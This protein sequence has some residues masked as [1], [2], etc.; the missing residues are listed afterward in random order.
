[1]ETIISV[2]RDGSG[3]IEQTV[4]M[5]SDILQMMKSMSE[6]T[7]ASEFELLDKDEL[8]ENAGNM[9]S[10]VRFVSAEP[11]TTEGFEGYKAVYSFDDINTL[12]INQNPGEIV[13]AP[14]DEGA[15]DD[16]IKEI[17]TF[18]FTEGEPSMV[19][20]KFPLNEGEAL[21]QE[22]DE[23]QGPTPDEGQ[24]ELMKQ[25]YQNMHL[26]MKMRFEGTIQ[27]TNASYRNGS[28]LTLFEMDF[29]KIFSNE[30]AID[31]LINSKP[32]TIQ[33]MKSMVEETAGITAEMNET[34]TVRYY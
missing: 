30:K 12:R 2:K 31:T 8:R 28:E 26:S 23:Q 33:A 6:E 5:Q 15:E 13:P 34:V 29:G 16:Q 17:I 9:G 4:L 24:M 1:M 20:I 10:G 18:T 7:E 22:K 25:L 21:S 3:T 19:T 27:E 11:M 32:E 14:E